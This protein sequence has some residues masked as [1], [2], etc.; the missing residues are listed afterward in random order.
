MRG[1]LNRQERMR[2]VKRE[3]K[4]RRGKYKEEEKTCKGV[5]N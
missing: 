3:I 5:S 4:E 1:S 2:E